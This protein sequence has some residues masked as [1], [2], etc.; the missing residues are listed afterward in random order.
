MGR[1]MRAALAALAFAGLAAAT[2][3]GAAQAPKPLF[4][5]SETIHLTLKAPFPALQRN[6]L[7]AD[8]KV[9]G[10]LT[11]QGVAA[12][13]LPVMLSV[14]GITRR[15]R[16]V[17]TFPPIRVEFPDKPPPASLFKGQKRLKLVTHCQDR[18]N[19][20]QHILLEYA[21]Y[22]MFNL[23]TPASFR[24]RLASIDYVDPNGRPVI[25]R[26]GYF[27]EDIDDVARRNGLARYKTQARVPPADLDPQAAARFVVFQDM[28]GNL[29]WAMTAGPA[30]TDCCHN[31]R[32]LSA[33]G[34]TSGFITV[35]YD[36]DFSGL[37]DAP[38]AT[39][40]EAFKLANVRVRK[41]RGYCR[42]NAEAQAFAAELAARRTAILGVLDETPQL[43]E[44]ARR[45][46]AEYLGGFFD[47]IAAPQGVT[48]M[49]QGCI[50]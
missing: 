2:P 8:D 3:A 42:H 1:V 46:A 13:T 31:S 34:A 47:Q 44:R 6:R 9:A 11:V 10:S 30:D 25:S 36:F 16:D 15:R 26:L 27:I 7:A 20:Q 28:I 48:T 22:R 49:L 14:R 45:K 33:K 5:G 29:D 4:A 32:L 41:Y 38:Y 35:P 12:E 40:P 19:F 37:V 39:P 50:G 24:V 23:L 21:A 17:C 43:D 18:E